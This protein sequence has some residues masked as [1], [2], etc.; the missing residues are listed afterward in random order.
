MSWLRESS[1]CSSP[2]PRDQ[3]TGPPVS[4]LGPD[5]LDCRPGCWPTIPRSRATQ[6]PPIGSPATYRTRWVTCHPI[7][8]AGVRRMGQGTRVKEPGAR[9]QAGADPADSA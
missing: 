2:Q 5:V 3:P 6:P 4:G 1:G 8:G 9:R 7:G